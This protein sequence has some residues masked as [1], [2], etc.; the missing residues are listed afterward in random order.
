MVVADTAAVV[1]ILSGNATNTTSATN[2]VVAVMAAVLLGSRA[3]VVAV[4]A[5]APRSF[6]RSL[7]LPI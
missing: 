2:A 5:L 7:L 1:R 6:P 3:Q 4:A